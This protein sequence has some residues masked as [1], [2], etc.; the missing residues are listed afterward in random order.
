MM[1]NRG[2]RARIHAARPVPSR[3]FSQGLRDT[4]AHL[5]EKRA[6]KPRKRLAAIAA[7]AAGLILFAALAGPP[8][9]RAASELWQ[10]LFAHKA[11]ELQHEQAL[12]EAQRVERNLTEREQFTR[13]HPITATA[14]AGGVAVTLSSFSLNATP[15]DETRGEAFVG[16]TFPNAPEGFDPAWVDFSLEVNGQV[17]LMTPTENVT[18]YRQ[19]GRPAGEGNGWGNVHFEGGVMHCEPT[20]AYDPWD[21]EQVTEF[22]LTAQ[23]NGEALRLPFTYDPARAHA[24]ALAEAQQSLPEADA[25][26]QQELRTLEQLAA[27]AVPI[28]ISKVVDGAHVTLEEMSLVDGK[29]YLSFIMT[30]D[31]GK[32]AK[33][34]AMDYGPINFRIDGIG[35]SGF[36]SEAERRDDGSLLMI[37]NIRFPRDPRKLPEESLIY[38][39]FQHVTDEQYEI[40]YPSGIMVGGLK[41]VEEPM[42]FQYNWETKAV[43][44]PADDAEQAAWIAENNKLAARWPED[45]FRETGEIFR[46]VWKPEQP[47]VQ[48]AGERR[49][50][51]THIYFDPMMSPHFKVNLTGLGD[52]GMPSSPVTGSLDGQPVTGLIAGRAGYDE[53][54]GMTVRA[55]LEHFHP[56]DLTGPALLILDFTISG[57]SFHFEIEIDPADIAKEIIVGTVESGGH[58]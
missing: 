10:R 12:P 5:P 6:S 38:M 35:G 20:F 7:W 18:D 44:L 40:E 53:S 52:E 54:D 32:R 14:Q 28:G 8:I 22:V 43:R 25:I 50:E 39:E 23:I 15:E 9:A 47:I 1:N 29:V 42:V 36:G 4:L 49:M 16:L 21:T 17:I 51:L 58:F 13:S 30:N 46:L 27:S 41:T 26:R 37:T 34:A 3:A 19:T 2:E 48:T 56:A 33:M 57:E 55:Q 45:N 24:A 31:S 11:Q